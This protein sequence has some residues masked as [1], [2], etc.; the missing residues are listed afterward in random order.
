LGGSAIIAIG[1]VMGFC[2]PWGRLAAADGPSLRVLTCNL[3]GRCYD[4][5]ALEKLIAE[6]KPDI[7]ALQGC[8]GEVRIR[9]PAGWHVCRVADFVV[10]SR[11]PVGHPG[12]D[13]SS[14]L[15]GHN[16]PHMDVLRCTIRALGREIDFCS[17]HLLSPHQGLE[18]VLD[19]KTL[20]RP[21]DSPILAAEIEH[22]RLQSEEVYRFACSLGPQPILAGDFNLPVDSVMYRQHW[23][24][25]RDAFSDGGLGFGYTEWPQMRVRVF[26]VRIDHVLMGEGWR[27]RRCWVG[28]DVGSDHLPLLADLS[29]TPT[30]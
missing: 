8:W 20:L 13:H 1:P 14:R 21:S 30:E 5:A 29:A 22:R 9:W 27:C 12:I 7:V 26:G 10:A 17:V 2:I 16:W 25:F 11:Y 24:T 18:A 6:S 28:A 19:R 15:P 3:K 4:N 23:S